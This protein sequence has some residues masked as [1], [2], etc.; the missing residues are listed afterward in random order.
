MES[1]ALSQSQDEQ[2]EGTEVV[3]VR[4]MDAV[5]T[6]ENNRIPRIKIPKGTVG[7]L[8]GGESKKADCGRIQIYLMV[9]T[10]IFIG[11]FKMMHLVSVRSDYLRLNQNSNS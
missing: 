2:L 4:D 3:F 8:T 10:S 7:I 5:S 9:K 1:R 11:N 6:E